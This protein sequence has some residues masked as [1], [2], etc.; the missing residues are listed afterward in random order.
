MS[1]GVSL[2]RLGL[3]SLLVQFVNVGLDNR[4]PGG[5]LSWK[6]EDHWLERLGSLMWQ[7][8]TSKVVGPTY[9]G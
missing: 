5:A 1:G 4:R 3:I 7:A 9:I 6:V 2:V 8:G